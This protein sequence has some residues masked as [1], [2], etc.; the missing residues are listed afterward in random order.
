MSIEG[1]EDFPLD[2]I[3]QAQDLH[4]NFLD[5]DEL[6]EEYVVALAEDFVFFCENEVRITNQAGQSVPFILNAPQR[7]VTDYAL[8]QLFS[9]KPLLLIILKLRQEAGFSTWVAALVSWLC[10]FMDNY[11]AMVISHDEDST[12]TLLSKYQFM[13]DNMSGDIKPDQDRSSRKLG[14]F[15]KNGSSVRIATAGTR[16]VAERKGRSKT[17]QAIH[18]SEPAFYQ[19]ARDLVTGVK[20]TVKLGPWKIIIFES[21]PNGR[22]GYFYDEYQRAKQGKSDYKAWFVPWHAV[23]TNRVEPTESQLSA[24]NLWQT[25]GKRDVREKAGFV[26]DDYDRIDRLGLDCAQWMWWG[27]AFRNVCDGDE[28]RMLQEYPDDDVSCFLSSGRSVFSHKHMEGQFKNIYE[29]TMFDLIEQ[30]GQLHVEEGESGQFRKWLDPEPQ[31]RYIA[32]ADVCSGS[33][34]TDYSAISIW[35]RRGLMLEQVASYIGRPDPDELA[36]MLD[37]LGRF[38]NNAVVCPESNTYGRHTLKELRKLAYPCIYRQVAWNRAEGRIVRNTLGF[39]TT[40]KSRPMLISAARKYLRASSKRIVIHDSDLLDQLGHFCYSAS[41]N[42]PQAMD[43]CHDDYVFTMMIAC[44]LDD[45]DS[46][47]DEQFKPVKDKDAPV[48]TRVSEVHRVED[49]DEE[50]D[51]IADGLLSLGL[52]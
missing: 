46:D 5:S 51:S 15:W 10:T 49:P 6:D 36:L 3:E 40:A 1:G 47:L 17:L 20:S 27:N 21:T 39:E 29:P 34:A 9:G 32:T 23:P 11:Q 12:D 7:R 4:Y 42:K 28:E 18:F 8:R 22:G 2:V 30:S 48:W 41:T 26:A 43:G 24:W 45:E 31:E 13:Y 50:F 33:T 14:M 25:T 52:Y 19:A 44:L 38:Y 37:A 35:C 16:A